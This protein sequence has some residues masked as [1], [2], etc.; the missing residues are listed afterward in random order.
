MLHMHYFVLHIKYLWLRSSHARLES[1]NPTYKIKIFSFSDFFNLK[2]LL[3]G[4]IKLLPV[5]RV[6]SLARAFGSQVK[7]A[8]FGDR[9]RAGAR[10]DSV[11]GCSSD[12][13]VFGGVKSG[14]GWS[15]DALA[16]RL[17][18]AGRQ[19]AAVAILSHV[20]AT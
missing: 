10:L 13:P 19:S 12:P 15:S 6:R 5:S 4:R 2:T 8:D 3:K 7:S 18:P 11:T 1:R 16:P 9:R 17:E 14:A 20:W